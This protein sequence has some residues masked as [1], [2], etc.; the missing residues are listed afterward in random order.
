[1]TVA[2]TPPQ[3]LR[4]KGSR[5]RGQELAARGVDVGCR[6]LV[7]LLA[8][9]ATLVLFDVYGKPGLVGGRRSRRRCT[10]SLS[11]RHSLTRGAADVN[12]ENRAY[13]RPAPIKT[14]HN[15]SKLHAGG[16]RYVGP[17]TANLLPREAAAFTNRGCH[18][19]L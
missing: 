14:P 4:G 15:P 1:M 8:L 11:Q 19:F 2:G 18:G 17:M 6:H 5:D 9:L 10:L 12:I 13:S 7:L 16:S 3:E